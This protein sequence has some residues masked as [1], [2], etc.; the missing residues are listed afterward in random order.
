MQLGLIFF[1]RSMRSILKFV[2]MGGRCPMDG[3]GGGGRCPL[4][5]DGVIL[6][7]GHHDH[8]F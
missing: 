7:Y 2:R 4:D 3:G 8:D 5:G 1:F 6:V